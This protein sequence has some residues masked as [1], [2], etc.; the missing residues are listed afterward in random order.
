MTTEPTSRSIYIWN[1]LGNLAAA[2]VSVL[3]LMLVSRVL[4]AEQADVF[5][6]AYAVG[7]MWVVLGLFQVRNY[8]GTDVRQM[9]RFSSYALARLLTTSFMLLTL[10]PYLLV[11]QQ[12]HYFDIYLYVILYRAC[13]VW[14]DL[15]QGLFQQKGRLDLAGKGMV[16]RYLGSVLLFALALVIFKNLALALLLL[17]IFNFLVVWVYDWQRAKALLETKVTPFFSLAQG[18]DALRILQASFPLFVSG[19]IL[20]DIFNAPR[21]AFALGVAEGSFPPGIQRDYSVLFMP[22]FFMSLC[23]LVVRPLMT[24]LAQHWVARENQQFN[25]I[26]RRLVGLVLLGGAAV[27]V[28]A[29]SLGAPILGWLFGLDLLSYR[30]T[31]AIFVFSG[32]LYALAIILENIL[33][34]FRRQK[35]LLLIY[36]LML[37]TSK[38]LTPYLVVRYQLLGA[39]WSFCA[40]MLVFVMGSACVYVLS[41]KIEEKHRR[42]LS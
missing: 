34:I 24:Q 1:L 26:V 40:V 8:Q 18:R 33:T 23:I 27:T 10:Y 20:V 30:G 2:G 4:T 15:F 6:L 38:S 31:L 14:S 21:R 35:H 9:H 11:Y 32:G 19:F 41:K 28:L 22:V 17:F 5:S 3:Y 29:Y 7:N 12:T 16:G 42:E 39:A 37:L 25:Q 36:L 13:D